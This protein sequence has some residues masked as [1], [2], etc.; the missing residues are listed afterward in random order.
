[1][2]RELCVSIKVNI[3]YH[4]GISG[5][6]VCVIQEAIIKQPQITGTSQQPFTQFCFLLSFLY[7]ARLT[8]RYLAEN[9]RQE[10]HMPFQYLRTRASLAAERTEGH[11]RMGKRKKKLRRGT[12]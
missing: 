7:L 6:E 1:M 3:E 11:E 2:L 12:S 5:T 9:H 10:L 4:C 8:Q